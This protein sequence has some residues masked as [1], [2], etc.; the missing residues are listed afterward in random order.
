M[1][2]MRNDEYEIYHTYQ[3]GNKLAHVVKHN[4]SGSWGIHMFKDG[5]S[6]LIEYYPTKNESWAE[7]AAENFVLGIKSWQVDWR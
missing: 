7:D 3:E 2:T 5:K 1:Q 6:G 4:N